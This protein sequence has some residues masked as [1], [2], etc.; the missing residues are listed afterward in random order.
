MILRIT[1]HGEIVLKKP[2][3]AVSYRAM[4]GELPKL[5]KNMWSSGTN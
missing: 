3:E 5:L 4:K 1:K 2:A